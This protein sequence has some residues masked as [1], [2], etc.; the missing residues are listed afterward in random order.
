MQVFEETGFQMRGV[1]K[2]DE[3]HYVERRIQVLLGSHLICH[4]H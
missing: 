2:D 1:A 4:Y 3:A